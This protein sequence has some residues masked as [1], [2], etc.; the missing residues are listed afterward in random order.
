MRN[1]TSIT[2]EEIQQAYFD[3][4]TAD[5]RRAAASLGCT[6]NTFKKAVIAY[7]FMFKNA[8]RGGFNSRIP[9]LDD[10]E[11]L[12]AKLQITSIRQLAAE[13]Q[14]TVGNI[15]DRIKRYGI[16]VDKSQ[17]KPSKP[18]APIITPF[19]VTK[20]D[21][22]LLYRAN[23]GHTRIRDLSGRKYGQL[24]IIEI[25][26]RDQYGKVHWKVK[27]ICGSITII[28][29]ENIGRTQS[30]GCLLNSPV[31]NLKDKRFGHLVVQSYIGGGKW[32]CLCDCGKKK[33]IW[34]D[35][36]NSHASHSCGCFDGN[37]RDPIIVGDGTAKIPLSQGKFAIIDERDLE[38]VKQYRWSAVNCGHTYYAMNSHTKNHMHRFITGAPRG[39][40]VDHKD[41]DGLNNKRDNLRITNNMVNGHNRKKK[42]FATS[43]Y[44]GVCWSKQA[45]KWH[46]SISYMGKNYFL[47]HHTDEIEAAQAYDRA[48]AQFY[49][50][51]ACTNF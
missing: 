8:G 27:C 43:K 10:K 49:G 51:D 32:L 21:G 39:T 15:G 5:G 40:V 16:V 48:A 9:L 35:Y 24:E 20:C 41:N 50:I 25:A 29:P 13:L 36:L 4:P 12:A 37:N 44:R 3:D 23:D 30:C 31:E 45:Q 6:Y 7:G 11:W 19:E 34:A 33:A 18:K 2:K 38:K 1:A 28:S 26:G 22:Y 47:G 46:A 42:P 14:T 17:R